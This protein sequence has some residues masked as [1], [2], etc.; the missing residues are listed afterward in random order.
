MDKSTKKVLVTEDDQFLANVITEALQRHGVDTTTALNGEE[1]IA[2][3]EE[4]HP[5]LLLLD[6]LMPEVDGYAV[7][8]HIKEK[9]YDIPSVILTNIS[10]KT[11]WKR[12]EDL[13]C[14]GFIV[15]STLDEDDIW[16]AVE[17]YLED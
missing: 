14:K 10:G 15:K 2:A 16:L 4:E 13:G 8:E 5:D 17:K 12:C 9:G 3:I 6:L 1:A 7:L 11:D